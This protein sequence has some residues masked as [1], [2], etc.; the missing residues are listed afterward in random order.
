MRI[1]DWSSDVCSSDLR[2][3]LAIAIDHQ[4]H[5]SRPVEVRQVEKV[6]RK[7][8]MHRAFDMAPAP[9]AT[10]THINEYRAKIVELFSLVNVY[11]H[12]TFDL[13]RRFRRNRKRVW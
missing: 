4:W 5:G 11:G 10:W 3:N 1:S 9:L 7:I 6:P 12:R 8:Q 2:A 13:T